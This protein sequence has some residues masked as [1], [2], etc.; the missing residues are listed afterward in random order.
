[1]LL[2]GMP[3]WKWAF[4]GYQEILEISKDNVACMILQWGG[5]KRA[6]YVKSY[7]FS[8]FKIYIP[9]P[10]KF[11]GENKSESIWHQFKVT[12]TVGLAELFQSKNYK[13][14]KFI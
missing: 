5:K 8:T 14:M 11:Y 7:G 2:L 3:S 9:I 10:A 13:P 1:M 6:L 4:L 12:F